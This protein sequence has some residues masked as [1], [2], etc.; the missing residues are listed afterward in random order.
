MKKIILSS[1]SIVTLFIMANWAKQVSDVKGDRLHRVNFYGRII[2]VGNQDKE[3]KIDNISIDNAIKQIPVYLAP[4][5]FTKN[6]NPTTFTITAN[7]KE[8]LTQV[9]IDPAEIRTVTVKRVEGNPVTW[10]YKDGDKTRREYIEIST[11]LNDNSKNNYLIDANK[12]LRFNKVSPAG[13][14]ESTQ[15][16]KGLIKLT[17]EGY[18]DRDLEKNKEIK[19]K[20]RKRRG[21][22]GLNHKYPKGI[23]TKK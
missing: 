19:E 21:K 6:I 22:K 17:I 13:P 11:T 4:T 18:K 23:P 1:L 14:L 5:T 9:K 16:F 20:Y 2:T 3:P 12:T 15:N 8:I 10:K 7:P